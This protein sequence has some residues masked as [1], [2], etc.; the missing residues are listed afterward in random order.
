MRGRESGFTLLEL[1][2]TIAVI[3]ILA[4]IAL[5]SFLGESRK[6]QAL[7]EVQPLF[8]DLRVRFEQFMQ[9]NGRYP[10]TIG[11][12]TLHPVGIPGT[13]QRAIN[14]LP[15]TWQN[16]KVR[17][18]GPDQIRCGYTWATGLADDDANI[19]PQAAAPLPSFNF[20]APSTEWYY[21]IAKCDMDGDGVFSWYFTS[22]ANPAI[23]RLDEGE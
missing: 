11:E 21:L 18:S 10:A 19:G 15:V 13:A 22:S 9:E 4:V 3:S 20:T 14:P 2:V 16:L 7:A 17:I 23:L 12:A 1:M 5:P 8:N 6:T